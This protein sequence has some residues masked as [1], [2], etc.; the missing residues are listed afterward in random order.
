MCIDG[1][2]ECLLELA[3][4]FEKTVALGSAGIEYLFWQH[5][6]FYFEFMAFLIALFTLS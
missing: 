3:A 2:N 6:I 1:V 5:R 4:N